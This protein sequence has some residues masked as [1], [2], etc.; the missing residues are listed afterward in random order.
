[1]NIG[2][3]SAA[4][5]K[6]H[7]HVD[8]S[9]ALDHAVR[10]GLVSYGLVHLL[11][12]WI[13]VQLA[14]GDASGSASGSGALS[15][16]AQTPV[17]GPLMYVVTAGFAAL[18]VWQG[19]EAAIGHRGLDGGKRTA[20]RLV[21]ALRVV[22]YGALGFSALKLAIGSGS[23]SSG[24][25]T[26]TARIM[27]LPFGAFLVGAVGLGILGYAGGLIYRGLGE[28]FTNRLK[29]RGLQGA[30]GTAVV[31]LGKVGYVAKGVALLVVAGLFLWAALAHDPQKSGGL[32]QALH[33]VLQQPYGAPALVLIGLGIG[34]YGAF[35]F[36]W[37]RHLDR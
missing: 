2:N 3:A 35:C 22:L 13:A 25:D 27:S 11:I 6:A 32:D 5:S 12:A 37:A 24:T 14:F 4:A 7:R 15:Q 34:C 1:M 26:L 18:V 31:L 23:G 33:T 20:K 8:G 17:G 30:S 29:L 28:G 19:A 36:A 21:S 16:L 10:V 9:D